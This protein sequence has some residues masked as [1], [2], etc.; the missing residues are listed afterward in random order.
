MSDIPK[1]LE[2]DLKNKNIVVF[3]GAGVSM[4]IRKRDGTP[5]FPSWEGFVNILAQALED[6]LQPVE[7]SFLEVAIRLRSSKY[8]LIAIGLAKEA[9]GPNLWYRSVR[10]AFDPR[11]ENVDEDSL[12]LSRLI[13]KLGGNLIIT[14]NVDPTLRWACPTPDN[15]VAIDGQKAEVAQFLTRDF[16]EKPT[17]WHLHGHVEDAEHVIFTEEQFKA[18]YKEGKNEAKLQSL[19]NFLARRTFIFIGYSLDDTYF[20]EQLENIDR[21]YSGTGPHYILLHKSFEGLTRLPTSVRPIYYEEFGKPLEDLIEKMSKIEL[22]FED[23]FMSGM[24]GRYEYWCQLEDGNTFE[25]ENADHGDIERGGVMDVTPILTDESRYPANEP[26]RFYAEIKAVRLWSKEK[27]KKKK[28]LGNPWPW[29][30]KSKSEQVDDDKQQFRFDYVSVDE[31][32]NGHTIDSYTLNKDFSLGNGTF[33][34][35]M[36]KGQAPGY[37]VKGHVFVRKMTDENLKWGPK[38]TKFT[39]EIK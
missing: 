31:D 23:K 38:D 27:G 26:R 12:K 36:Q 10:K 16:P 17:V 2:E 37:E 39:G 5:L 4:S 29:Q 9:L 14:T 30:S 34:H 33:V 11:R 24:Q 1:F 15:F 7:A 35:K 8:L 25:G 19:L 28:L 13:W 20:R 21:M 6:N 3:V 32:T 22:D 18:F